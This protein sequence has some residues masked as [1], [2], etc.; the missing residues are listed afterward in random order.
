MDRSK[1]PK[2]VEQRDTTNGVGSPVDEAAMS[3]DDNFD[4][5]IKKSVD[6]ALDA[7]STEDRASDKRNSLILGGAAVLGC[8]SIVV[9]PKAVG[10]AFSGAG[11]V[12]S[13]SNWK[14]AAG[15]MDRYVGI[16]P[17]YHLFGLDSE[18]FQLHLQRSG[19]Q[20]DKK[21]NPERSVFARGHYALLESEA[22]PDYVPNSSFVFPAYPG[23]CCIAL[24]TGLTLIDFVPLCEDHHPEEV[25]VFATS[26][27]N[28]VWIGAQFFR[29]SS[30]NI[31]LPPKVQQNLGA[32]LE[33]QANGMVE[34][35]E[36]LQRKARLAFECRDKG[37]DVMWKILA[38]FQECNLEGPTLTP[39][40][41]NDGRA[42]VVLHGDDH[43]EET[44]NRVSIAQ[45][46]KITKLAIKKINGECPHFK[47]SCEQRKNFCALCHSFC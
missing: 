25:T 21:F 33:I 42:R 19:I 13:A 34:Q 14:A 16:L 40:S 31:V 7:A 17:R 20:R 22:P 41:D 38:G 27:N 36:R 11:F 28:E 1:R 43:V 29:N 8:V 45:K 10:V 39:L 23:V 44:L 18:V 37:W 15:P 24:T 26:L 3:R 5:S 6:V 12:K 32:F 47:Q 46:I 2:T 9:A 4:E 35:G 30:V